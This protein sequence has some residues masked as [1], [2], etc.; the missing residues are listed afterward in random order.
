ML[1][2]AEDDSLGRGGDD[3]DE[4]GGDHHQPRPPPLPH[5]VDGGERTTHTD[6]HIA[7]ATASQSGAAPT[8]Q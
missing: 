1:E 2:D 6:T 3:G 4:P 8:W 5:R 7:P